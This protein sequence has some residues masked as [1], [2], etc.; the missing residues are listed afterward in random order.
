MS[1]SGEPTESIDS[2]ENKMDVPKDHWAIAYVMM[3]LL[4]MGS[5][6]PWTFFST[7]SD[8]FRHA[9]RN[10]TD[11]NEPSTYA[12]LYESSLAVVAMSCAVLGKTKYWFYIFINQTLILISCFL[13]GM[14][15]NS[16]LTSRVSLKLRISV[17]LWIV[18]GVFIV[19]TVLT[20][21][22]TDSWQRGF[23]ILTMINVFVISTA[24]NVV[25]GGLFGIQACLP[26][27]FATSHMVGKKFAGV[28]TV[29]ANII[30]I[31]ATR[32]T[33]N[34]EESF[35]QQGAGYFGSA[36]VT[37]LLFIIAFPLFFRLRFVQYY[38]NLSKSQA[39]I[40]SNDQGNTNLMF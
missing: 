36:I 17:G 23:F 30:L 15:V 2:S 18:T 27:E 10:T 22:D 38:Y 29:I 13:I 20:L 40:K 16:F 24:S 34:K 26:Q 7:A 21:I 37:T 35:R 11:P 19:T 14:L 4:G 12:T 28:F 31:V 33:S 3:A 6:F 25:V 9:F 8:Y 1:R 32:G 39:T 5:M